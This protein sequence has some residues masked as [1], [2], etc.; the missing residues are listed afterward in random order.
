MRLDDDVQAVGRRAH[1]ARPEGQ[2]CAF[3]PREVLAAVRCTPWPLLRRR[4]AA[5]DVSAR[6]L[7]SFTVEPMSSD[8]PAP[9]Q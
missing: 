4:V 9:T 2:R 6:E 7:L 8:S 5:K 3:P 1:L